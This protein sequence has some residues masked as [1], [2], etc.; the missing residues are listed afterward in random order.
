MPINQAIDELKKYAEDLTNI[1]DAK[2][3]IQNHK[4][5]FIQK[6][7]K[8]NQYY[9]YLMTNIELFSDNWNQVVDI[10]GDIQ[11]K[12]PTLEPWIISIMETKPK[13][14]EIDTNNE[15]ID[16]HLL[17]G[18]IT[19]LTNELQGMQGW[20]PEK[21]EDI[22]WNLEECQKMLLVSQDAFTP[23]AYSSLMNDITVSLNKI[24]NFYA[25]LNSDSMESIKRM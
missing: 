4:E 12:N 9:N 7:A 2:Q 11:E 22:K 5:E 18:K 25:M 19:S 13:K 3:F 14:Q 8:V 17:Q 21:I 16:S 20:D 15:S 6:W 24:E 1:G 10:M 23:Q